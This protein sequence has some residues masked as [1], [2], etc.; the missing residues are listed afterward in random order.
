MSETAAALAEATREATL[1]LR[2]LD[3]LTPHLDRAATLLIDAFA[4]GRKL[5]TCGNGGSAADAAHLAAEFVVRFRRDRRP[6]PALALSEAGPNLTA[7]GNDYDFAD[8]FARQVHAFGQPGDVLVCF[9]TS[10]NSPNILHA[11]HAAHEHGVHTVAFLGRGG[12]D[13]A[14][15]ADVALTVPYT[16]STARIQEAHILLYHV[17][18]ERVEAGLGHD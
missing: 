11:L 8:C 14:P 15:V 6:Y 1:V 17:L 3:A 10:G 9:S 18:C 16:T 7:I 2:S 5:L 13:A 4:D 12:G